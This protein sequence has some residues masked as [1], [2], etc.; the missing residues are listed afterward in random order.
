ML[1]TNHRRRAH[2]AR[3]WLGA[4]AV[5]GLLL[6]AF[7]AP[8]AAALPKTQ[9]SGAIVSP[10]TG[11]T[12][13]S[14]HFTVVYTNADGA[15]AEWVTITIRGEVHAMARR[16][17]GDWGH[18]VT[19]EWS[20]TLATGTHAVVFNARSR[21]HGEASLASGNVTIGTGATPTPTPKPTP[22]PT[23]KPTPTP[24]PTPKP[25]P[26][27]TPHPTPTP[28]P[29][30][31]PTPKRT[32]TPAKTTAPAA[33]PT[34]EPTATSLSTPSPDPTPIASPTPTSSAL[35]LTAVVIGG[36]GSVGPTQPSSDGTS[37]SGG[38]GTGGGS[39]GAGG[40]VASLMALTGLPLPTFGPFSF[41]PTLVTTTGAVAAAMAFGLFGRRRRDD[42]PPDE[43]VAAAAA[44]GVGIV[45][46]DL[47]PESAEVADGL[48]AASGAVLAADDMEALMPRWRRPS[49][50]QARRADPIRDDTP[51]PRLTFDQGLTGPL[52]GHERRV[53]RYRVVRLL[54]TPDELRGAEI[55]YLDKGDEVQLLEKYG[56]YWL[57][58]SP[59][60]QQGWLHKMVL[61]DLV[62]GD[63]DDQAPEGPVA[64]MPIAADSWTMGEAVS[65]GD[66]FDA[67]LESRRRES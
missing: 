67:Y 32:A 12:T 6:L 21:D 48:A 7:A 44:R 41:G 39:H 52:G 53:I 31:R 17:D 45:P 66:V 57:V 54:D 19:F 58:L 23:P 60:G 2:E 25:T 62:G 9:L 51:A 36:T 64:T 34:T 8:M 30:P 46:R 59:D 55:G 42:D 16:S 29:T 18:G 13:T 1:V 28:V 33:E 40:P 43:L 47:V 27:A 37:G 11:T 61:G 56:A 65:E 14:I 20:G 15:R 49:L 22:T 24:V 10:R 5:A 35:P 3:A 50:L 4:F 63:D 26:R 38:A